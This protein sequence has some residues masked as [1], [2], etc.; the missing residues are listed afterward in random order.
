MFQ[1]LEQ[2]PSAEADN[3][4][5]AI[6]MLFRQTCILE[7]KYD[8]VTL[9]PRDNP[10]YQVCVRHKSF[11]EDYLEVLGCELWHDVQEHIFRLAG[12]GAAAERIGLTSTIIVLL[13]KLIYR[14]KIMG[15]GLLAPVTTLAEIRKYGGDTGLLT[16]RLPI[17]EWREALSLMKTHQMIELPGA[18]QNVEDNTPIYLYSTIQI[19][20][21][22]A[23]IRELIERY[24][25]AEIDKEGTVGE[26]Q[27]GKEEKVDAEINIEKNKK[28][29]EW[30]YEAGEGSEET[31]DEDVD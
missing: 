2:L 4:Q 12:S 19:Y 18:V 6:R 1:Y 16:R 7:R 21:S 3:I 15:E 24:K 10:Y 17:S 30:P 5:R 22:N 25:E 9:V 20:C 11:L 26:V 29:E 27:I 13:L 23:D 31:T 28:A 14:D 8:P